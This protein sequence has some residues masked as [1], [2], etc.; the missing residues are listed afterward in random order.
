MQKILSNL[1]IGEKFIITAFKEEGDKRVKQRLRDMGAVRGEIIEITKIAPLGDPIEIKIKGY[2]LSLRKK[3]ASLIKV[4][5]LEQ[6]QNAPENP[7]TPNPELPSKAQQSQTPAPE[8]TTPQQSIS[9]NPITTPVN[10][11]PKDPN[12]QA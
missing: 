12:D 6:T 1:N 3:E 7:P 10:P 5:P 8:A 4:E 2:S 11:A 9:E